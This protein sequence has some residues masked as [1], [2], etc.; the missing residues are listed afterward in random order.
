MTGRQ[1]PRSGVL[2]QYFAFVAKMT[3]DKSNTIQKVCGAAAILAPLFVLVLASV[4]LVL[5]VELI[6]V[7]VLVGV[8]AT[9]ACGLGLV[10]GVAIRRRRKIRPGANVVPFDT[11]PGK[12]RRGGESGDEGDQAA[13]D[14]R[15]DPPDSSVGS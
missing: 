6:D 13:G 11:S 2:A 10:A 12:E 4:V 7:R 9:G 8:V 3:S 1:T 5:K 14:D 15:G